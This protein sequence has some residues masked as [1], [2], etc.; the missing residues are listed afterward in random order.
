MIARGVWSWC[1]PYNETNEP[2]IAYTDHSGC[3]IITSRRLGPKMAKAARREFP[4]G[5]PMRGSKL[6]SDDAT[7]AARLSRTAAMWDAW[8]GWSV[9]VRAYRA[10][11]PS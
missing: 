9:R 11:D 10:F 6:T 1:L 8:E 5:S 7:C 3:P 2:K 4:R